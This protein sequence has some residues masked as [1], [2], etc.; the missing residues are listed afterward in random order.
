MPSAWG[1]GC[2][3]RDKRYKKI[4]DSL[5]SYSA[6]RTFVT[7]SVS[8]KFAC[9]EGVRLT[10]EQSEELSRSESRKSPSAFPSLPWLKRL[11]VRGFVCRW[12]VYGALSIDILREA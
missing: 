8:R 11:F 7:I 4:V 5:W 6:K 3:P 10:D 1:L 9:A 2:N 12:I